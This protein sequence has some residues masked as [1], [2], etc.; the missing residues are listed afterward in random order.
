[1]KEILNYIKPYRK[2]AILAPLFMLI[3]ASSELIMPKLM[4]LLINHGVAASNSNYI[5][6]MG[7]LMIFISIIGIIGGI[8]CLICASIASQSAGTD[9]RRDLFIKIQNF[10]F[11][12]IDTFQTPSLITRLTND[13]TQIQ[14]VILMSLRMLIRA[15][16]LCFGS[17]I[18][19]FTIQA[20]LAIIFVIAI[21]ILGIVT[22]VIMRKGMPKFQMVQK[23]LDS[24]NTVMRECL[25]GMRV[26]KAFVRHDYE[27]EKFNTAND[28]YKDTSVKA[29]RIV[30]FMLP[31]MMLILNA[32]IIAI[33]WF[34]GIQ[35]SDGSL[36]IEELM[37]FIT[38]LMQM[39]L[40]LMMIAMVFMYISRAQISLTRIKEVLSEEIDIT[41]PV[42]PLLPEKSL[43][44]VAFQNVSFRYKGGSGEPVLENISFTV[45][46][47]ETI[48]IIG[49]TGS[50]KSTLVN[51]M[52]RLYDVSEGAIF[53]DGVDVRNYPIHELR[54][55]VSVVLQE[56]ILFTGTIRE[57]IKWG[58]KNAD[59]M[60]V[61]AAAKAAQAHDFILELPNGYD[62]ELGQKGVN[63]S[64]GQKQRISIAR[65]L[66]QNPSIIIFDDSTSAV[67]SLTEK[68]I[69][70]SMK[71]SHSH[72]TKFIIA[73]RISSIQEADKIFVLKDGKIAAQGNHKILMETSS[74]YQEIYQSQMKK[75][76]ILD[77]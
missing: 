22:F 59:E 27:M 31:A 51:L 7:I 36:K 13:I 12:N 9:L 60:Q 58:N 61:M 20:D 14:M 53:I 28:N 55:R 68:R 16:L 57:N 15:P 39:I 17:L 62:T 24:V 4:T 26:V 77:A 2:M 43:G 63:V 75:G 66:I 74:D 56:T 67:D 76:V 50:G 48:G 41:D 47:G 45:D 46:A 18:M 35:F 40:A 11:H 70:H 49:E 37:A 10:S 5:V 72:C 69:R 29:F 54:K 33:L 8:G 32:S 64:G 3:E 65:A 30:I 38:Y 1:M 21:I 52:P 44:S 34:G 6:K 19:A 73:Q 25:A 23:K 71:E 42:N